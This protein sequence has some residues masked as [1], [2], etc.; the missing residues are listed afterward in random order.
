MSSTMI[1]QML[2]DK[3]S[4]YNDPFDHW[5]IDDFF[6]IDE[7][8]KLSD[9]FIDFKRSSILQCGKLKLSLSR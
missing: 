8:N 2:S 5:V 7:A 4:Y 1:N 9:E 6:D 3:I